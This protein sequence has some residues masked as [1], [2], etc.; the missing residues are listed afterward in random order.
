MP[1]DRK[2]DNSLF[3]QLGL[4][5]LSPNVQQFLDVGDT[6]ADIDNIARIADRIYE[7]TKQISSQLHSATVDGRISSLRKEVNVFLPQAHRIYTE[8]RPQTWSQD[9]SSD[10]NRSSSRKPPAP[11]IPWHHHMYGC[12]AR[13]CI[14]PCRFNTTEKRSPRLSL[15]IASAS[16]IPAHSHMFYIQ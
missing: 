5:W 12:R 11:S 3:Y 10:G 13:K 14:Q 2:I 16:T 9:S 7:R 4:W 8:Q 15:V 6:D 1:G